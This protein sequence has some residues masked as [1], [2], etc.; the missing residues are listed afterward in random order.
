MKVS[1]DTIIQ[2]TAFYHD[3]D[4]AELLSGGQKW[5]QS[6]ARHIGM[7]LAIRA[8]PDLSIPYVTN[9]FG[10]KDHTTTYY[11]DQRV[12]TLINEGDMETINMVNRIAVGCGLDAP[13]P[14]GK[15]TEIKRHRRKEVSQKEIERLRALNRQKS[16][17]AATVFADMQEAA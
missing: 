2:M 17:R 15:H 14:F 11:A 10:K 13:I 9:R 7:W 6:H 4:R 12:T 5:R 8:R 3:M 16:D 1:L